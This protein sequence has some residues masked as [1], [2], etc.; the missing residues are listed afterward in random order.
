MKKTQTIGFFFTVGEV[1]DN[2]VNIGNANA[3]FPDCNK[4]MTNKKQD[5]SSSELLRN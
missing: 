3:D 4:P 5:S 2:R 1:N